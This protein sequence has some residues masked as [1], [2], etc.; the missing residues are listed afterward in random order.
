[1]YVLLVM[2]AAYSSAGEA[3]NA[4]AIATALAK[5]DKVVK[6]SW[7]GYK[8][9][10]ATEALQ[11][12]INSGAKKVVIDNAGE[13]IVEPI[14]L[15]SDQAIEIE[16]GVVITA[17]RGA[18][19][20]TSDSLFNLI[21]ISNVVIDGNGALLR[22]WKS[23]YFS[24]EYKKGEWRTGITIASGS[25][26]TVDGITIKDSGG[27]GIYLGNAGG[28]QPYCKDIVIRNVVCDG[29]ARQG[30]SVISAENLLIENCTLI[31]TLGTPPEAG[32]DFEPNFPHERLANIVVRNCVAENNKGG[33]YIVYFDNFNETTT[34]VSITY[35]NC[36]AKNNA[37]GGF[38]YNFWQ[39][40]ED[41]PGRTKIRMLN[42]RAE[43]RGSNETYNTDDYVAGIT[44][45]VLK[46]KQRQKSDIISR[47]KP[48]SGDG[49][50]YVPFKSLTS[51]VK[52][53]PA[54]APTPQLREKLRCLLYARQ[55]ETATF[56]VTFNKIGEADMTLALDITSPSGNKIA[57]EPAP[58]G[59][60]KEYQFAATETGVYTITG[61]AGLCTAQLSSQTHCLSI[62]VDTPLNI[63]T[64]TVSLYFLVP[65]GVKD[66]YAKVWG[67]VGEK[68][69]A[70]LIDPQG[71]MVNK[72]DNIAE[73]AFKLAASRKNAW[74]DEVWAIKFEKPSDGSIIEDY[75]LSLYGV[76]P[77]VAASKAA[78]L[79]PQQ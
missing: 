29:N 76:P 30:I 56:N 4:V 74:K 53:P 52:A 42:C 48:F 47:T 15:A 27:D 12:A 24:P 21:G 28:A 40:F 66:F 79:V 51:P 41:F 45:G 39:G 23:D 78:L 54:K 9:A 55:G 6:A 62:A 69:N 32:I 50:T 67:S 70:A 71:A 2:L 1:M 59:Q 35:D 8:A 14:M 43:V 22:M 31:N 58:L 16:Q 68:V 26:I 60:K 64:S 36:S 20:G 19:K 44:A 33:G 25:N 34:N 57:V 11:A 75:Y 46:F 73:Y 5:P 65:A 63:F 61:L 18:F 77:V 17:K 37:F 3:R 72:Q 10:E 7:F 49:K 13:W 38:M